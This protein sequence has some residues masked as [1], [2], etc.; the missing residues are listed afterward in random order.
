MIHS[1]Q[2][3]KKKLFQVLEGHDTTTGGGAASLQH[4]FELVN[5]RSKFRII[6]SRIGSKIKWGSSPAPPGGRSAG[7]EPL[8]RSPGCGYWGQLL[9]SAAVSGSPPGVGYHGDQLPCAKLCGH[10]PVAQWDRAT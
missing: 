5:L 8:G 9:C 1:F 4:E 3:R 10:E 7:G 2:K 6:L